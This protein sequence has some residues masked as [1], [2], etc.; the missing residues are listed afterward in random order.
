[1]TV[2]IK[3]VCHALLN[4]VAVIIIIAKIV[5]LGVIFVV[6]GYALIA[7]FDARFVIKIFATHVLFPVLSVETVIA[8]IV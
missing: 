5:F 1:M 6:A 4:A 8:K 2:M 3:Y 7:E